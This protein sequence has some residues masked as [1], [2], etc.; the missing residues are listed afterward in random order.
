M[1]I[2][3][4]QV[5]CSPRVDHRAIYLNLA[6]LPET[7]EIA[8]IKNASQISNGVCRAVDTGVHAS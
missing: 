1:Q 5:H 6:S 3:R 8:A 2:Q 7:S 4:W